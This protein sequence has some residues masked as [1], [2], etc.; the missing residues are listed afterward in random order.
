MIEQDDN[1][2]GAF[3]IYQNLRT[4]FTPFVLRV[5]IFIWTWLEPHGTKLAFVF[6]FIEDHR[7]LYVLFVKFI[8][9]I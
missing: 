7:N 3:L 1:S 9:T 5:A 6:G 2:I 4:S 8:V